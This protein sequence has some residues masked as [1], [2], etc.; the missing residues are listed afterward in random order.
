MKR[1]REIW[2]RGMRISAGNTL[3]KTLWASG[4]VVSRKDYVGLKHSTLW[5]PKVVILKKSAQNEV[6]RG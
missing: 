2:I 6:R 1:K 3:N 5:E 4:F